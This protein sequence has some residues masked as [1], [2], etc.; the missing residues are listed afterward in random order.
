MKIVITGCNGF[1]GA[2]LIKYL[3]KKYP[4][5]YL[6][7]VDNNYFGSC[8]TGEVLPETLL[9]EIHYSDLR[10]FPY[11]ILK[12]VNSIILLAAIS[13]DPIGKLNEK[14]SKL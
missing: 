1:V 4:E 13:N 2:T 14:F 12:G 5:A 7:G 3:R 11:N 6:I 8:I 10:N 9:N